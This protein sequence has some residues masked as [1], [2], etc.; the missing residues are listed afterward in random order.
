[1]IVSYCSDE[2]RGEILFVLYKLSIHGYASK[3]CVGADVLQAFCPSLLRLSM[4]ALLKTQRDDVRLNGVGL[5]NYF[6]Y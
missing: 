2:I 1:M 3:D 6:V 5:S 4:E